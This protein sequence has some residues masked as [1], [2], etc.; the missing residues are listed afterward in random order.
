[1]IKDLGVGVDIEMVA[2]FTTP[3]PRLFTEAELALCAASSY[4][5]ESRAGRWCAKEA[6][7]KAVARYVLLSP[8]E[9]EILAD[10]DGRPVVRFLRSGLWHIRCDVSIT[11]GGGIAAAVS[12]SWQVASGSTLDS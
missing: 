2:R 7:V 6:V 12:A 4:P 10:P 3:D 9:V 8:R 1:M 5:A 11:H